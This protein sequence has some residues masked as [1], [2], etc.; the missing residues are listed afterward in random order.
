MANNRARAYSL[1]TIKRL[2]A[3]SGNRCAFPDCDVEFLNW[4]DDTN[5]SNICHIEDA[6]P[7]THKADRYNPNMTDEKRADYENLLLLC[8]NHHIETN[9][10]KKY[11]VDVLR[12]MK[13]C[14]EEDITQKLSKQNIITKHPSALNIVIRSLGE[15][16]FDSTKAKEPLSAPDPEEK[17]R[18]NNVIRYKGIIE[19]HKIY[20]GRLNKIYEEIENQGSTIKDYVLKNINAIY[21]KERGKY[22]DID[23]IRENADDII[24]KVE[25]KLWDI[26]ESSS[27]VN[28]HLPIEAIHISLY[29]VLVDAFMRCSFLEEPPKQ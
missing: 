2:Y 17:I 22:S 3:L 12:E 18:Y 11:S 21:L 10:T 4:E 24:G 19:E 14:H 29:V 7:N 13:R 25:A 8:A 15:R 1:L 28:S 16:L 26:I 27:N 9:N 6:N 23:E 20:Q 5:F